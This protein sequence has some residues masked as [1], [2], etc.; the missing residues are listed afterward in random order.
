[1]RLAVASAG[2]S[3]A[4]VLLMVTAMRAASTYYYTLAQF[5]AL[6]AAAVG[7]S[8]KVNGTIGGHVQWSYATQELTFEVL[9]AAAASSGGTAVAPL[10]VVY[11]GA[12]PDTFASGISV[13]VAGQLEPS[14]TFLAEQ[15]LVKCPS[16]YVAAS[17]ST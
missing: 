4:L 15:V 2:I 10:P 7:R 3:V 17:S 5:R 9:P 12:E 11:H 16:T 14:G 8:V 6:G 13:V 1:M